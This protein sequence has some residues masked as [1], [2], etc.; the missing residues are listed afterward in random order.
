MKKLKW[1]LSTLPTP[2]EL[3]ELVKNKILTQE[4]AKEILFKEEEVEKERDINSFKEEIKFLRELV[5]TLSKQSKSVVYEYIQ[6][7][8]YPPQ[9]TWYQPY[10]TWCSNNSLEQSSVNCSLTQQLQTNQGEQSSQIVA[11]QNQLY[12]DK[13]FGDI[14]TF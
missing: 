11:Y 10:I 2:S 5:D 9:W 13:P 6:Q 4:E 1:R 3:Q 14:Q 8:A 7:R 12:S